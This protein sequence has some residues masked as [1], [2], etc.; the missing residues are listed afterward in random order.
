MKSKIAVIFFLPLVFYIRLFSQETY[1]RYAPAESQ[2]LNVTVV[3]SSDMYPY[4]E[5][6]KGLEKKL[7]LPVYSTVLTPD[8]Q[9]LPKSD[10]TI[11]FGQKAAMV[12]GSGKIIKSLLP[13]YKKE[14]D[15]PQDNC[16]IVSMS[17]SPK[18]IIA[19]VL[20]LQPK[21]SRLGFI[22]SQDAADVNF[23]ELERE[24]AKK[25][26]EI[27]PAKIWSEE[28]VPNELR[29]LG[30]S[31]DALIVPFDPVVIGNF[32]FET[33][34]DFS[35]GN[36]IPLYVFSEKLLEKGASVSIGYSFEDIGQA[37]A[38]T[39]SK[40]ISGE[41]VEKIS[42]PSREP[43]VAVNPE[44]AAKTGVF[45]LDRYGDRIRYYE[46]KK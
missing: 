28:D 16:Y 27:K 45:V 23:K 17:P 4:K 46:V 1:F 30:N 6:L 15:C 43:Y 29:K 7:D 33:I 11:T 3:L 8:T 19:K 18:E 21:A 12:R 2:T 9:I 44:T 5:A 25:S 26:I 20:M 22:F 36:R 37:C 38:E 34:K 35:L 39:A 40:L 24:A 42:F 13:Y 32:S 41:R 14:I 31:L 10:I